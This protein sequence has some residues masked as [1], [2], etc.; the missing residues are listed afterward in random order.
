MF[1]CQE[2]D[3]YFSANQEM[4]QYAEAILSAAVC[5]TDSKTFDLV[6]DL[7]LSLHISHP[8]RIIEFFVVKINLLLPFVI[9]VKFGINQFNMPISLVLL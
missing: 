5:S 4:V 8:Y 2:V 7:S 3:W 1:K 6:F 9:L